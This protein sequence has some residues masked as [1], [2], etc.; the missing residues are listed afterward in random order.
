VPVPAPVPA[1]AGAPQPGLSPGAELRIGA[2][3]PLP[4]GAL[5]SLYYDREQQQLVAGGKEAALTVF[6]PG[7]EVVQQ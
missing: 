7:G 4:S 3:L 2:Q 5:Y 1:P 6:G